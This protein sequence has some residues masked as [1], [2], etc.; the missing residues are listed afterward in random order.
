MKKF[1]LLRK[2]LLQ[3]VVVMIGRRKSASLCRSRSMSGAVKWT[4]ASELKVQF[5]GHR[6]T[7]NVEQK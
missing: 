6:N 3:V 5:N 7:E 4:H 2:R 1:E